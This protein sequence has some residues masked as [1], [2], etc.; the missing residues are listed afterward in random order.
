MKRVIILTRISTQ[1]QK[2][3]RQILELESYCKEH[4][5][6]IVKTISSIVSGRKNDNRPDL[7]E[8]LIMARKKVFDI[9][10][11]TEI[12]RISRKP[13]VLQSFI[14]SLKKCGIPILFKNLGLF[15][16]D[17]NGKDS[18]ATNVII[19]IFSELTA[20]EVRQLSERVISG[21][22]AAKMRGK[23]IGRPAVKESNSKILK[24]HSKIVKYL[25]TGQT[26]PETAKL[27]GVA[28]NTVKKIKSLL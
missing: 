28:Y 6:H 23:K 16:I 9:L 7:D 25:Q 12:S 20:E 1:K 8:I 24:K 3:D 4:N 10:I 15:S 5:Y 27:C 26:L 21:L 22:E 11:V 14:S 19:A 17:E 13:E 2:T 18:F